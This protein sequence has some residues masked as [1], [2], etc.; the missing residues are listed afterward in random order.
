MMKILKVFVILMAIVVALSVW[1]WFSSKKTLADYALR[2]QPG[3]QVTEAR[4]YA[5]Q[6]GLK[7]VASSYRD[8]AG[9][10]HDLVTSSGVMGRYVCE[11]QHDGTIV[12]KV[13][14]QF[15]D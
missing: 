14:R 12:I 6:K 5:R 13:S 11:I 10:F 1:N 15:H 3:M 4:S 9:R 2:V 7:Y 8:E